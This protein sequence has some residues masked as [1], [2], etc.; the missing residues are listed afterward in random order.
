MD[1]GCDRGDQGVRFIVSLLIC[2][3]AVTANAAITLP[4]ASSIPNRTSG[5]APLSVFFD[6]SGT[7]STTASDAFS[8]IEYRWSF[9]DPTSGT[10][11]DRS[12]GGSGSGFNTARN[13]A[14][15]P[16][17]AHVFETAGTYTVRL[18]AYDGVSVAST[19][20]SITVTAWADDTNTICVSTT[21]TFT[22][23]AFGTQVSTSDLA[24]AMGNISSTK[25][26]ILF[27]CG[28]S[29]STASTYTFTQSAGLVGAYN[30][31]GM[32]TA[33]NPCS[34]TAPQW[35]Y[36][37]T[38]M[39]ANA[40]ISD[41]RITD[42]DIIGGEPFA[43][44]EHNG[45]NNW[46][47]LRINRHGS[48]FGMTIGNPGTGNTASGS[49]IVDTTISPHGGIGI[50]IEQQDKV[51]ILGTN[52]F[53]SSGEHNVRVQ[54]SN[55]MVINH[56]SARN[57]GA[58]SAAS[59]ENFAMRESD[60]GSNRPMTFVILSDNTMTSTRTGAANGNG[61]GFGID[62]I[63]T[64]GIWE[65]NYC[66]VGTTTQCVAFNAG[67]TGDAN[68]IT[69]RNNIFN[70][71]ASASASAP[72]LFGIS[73]L[74]S[75]VAS[76][77][78]S[79]YNNTTYSGNSSGSFSLTVFELGTNAG[80]HIKNNLTYAPNMTETVISGGSGNDASNNGTT[81][82]P[83][84]SNGSGSM[85]LPGDFSLLASSYAK[86]AGATLP[87]WSDFFGKVWP[88]SS[89]KWDIGA[90]STN[91]RARGSAK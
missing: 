78:L 37:P 85:S 14:R 82:D 5:K 58:S 66:N 22:G 43:V 24:T 4:S 18:L 40:G 27:R 31:S 16:M 86:E 77:G 10:W 9:G 65:R 42:L 13:E 19:S 91:K 17:A 51:A 28:E 56:T 52:V 25:K 87:L 36:G 3:L 39:D 74:N 72:D 73:M 84:F 20:M 57:A 81:S 23:C 69:I 62:G 68:R 88:T 49:M 63:V 79:I 47:W 8:Q 55:K 45:N 41:W 67:G 44:A 60:N 38:R 83:S 53:D 75:S 33:A 90:A 35:D 61:P 59:K 11:G 89:N 50:W 2:V 32:V 12:T 26:R 6:A 70:L 76:G 80:S 29:W 71:N 1:Y 21:S 7:T 34:G 54:G 30:N 48:G 64:D 15:G 46:L